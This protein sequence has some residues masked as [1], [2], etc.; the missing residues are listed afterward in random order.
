MD[1]DLDLP[2][3]VVGLRFA[4][5]SA[6]A[7]P[8]LV[9]L[10]LRRSAPRF[11]GPLERAATLLLDFDRWVLDAAVGAAT[12]VVIAAAW[13][14]N[15]VD[16]DLASAPVDAA[17]RGVVRGAAAA[18]PVLGGSLGRIFWLF[19]ALLGAACIGYGL[20]PAR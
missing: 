9:F 5:A 3:A 10:A 13:T 4:L 15:V 19:V 11:A 7:L 14:A 12:T 18:R 17:A 2:R 20:W 8:I 6:A 1:G 16:R